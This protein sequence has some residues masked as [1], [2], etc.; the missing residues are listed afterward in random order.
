MTT[1]NDD[2]TR[3]PKAEFGFPRTDLRRRLVNAVLSGEKT[4]TAGLLADF[5]RDGDPLPRPGE[6]YAVVDFDD[7]PVGVIETVEVRVVPMA[8]VDLQFAIDEGEGF[9]SVA[10]WRTA[11][12]R[13]FS[14]YIDEIRA[15][16]GDPGWELG[17]E[18]MIV[19]ER[20]R[21]VSPEPDSTRAA[22]A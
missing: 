4:A 21:L 12:E 16:V 10:E 5:E 19:C 2:W 8:E 9:G 13:F 1:G 18:T 11:H 17:D 14:S 22:P 20:F 7:R 15:G 3:L 6:R